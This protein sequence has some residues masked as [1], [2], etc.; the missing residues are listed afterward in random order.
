MTKFLILFFIIFT[1]T[2]LSKDKFPFVK[3]ELLN[4]NEIQLPKDIKGKITVII[5]AFE[6]NA[7][8]QIDPWTEALLPLENN[9]D[10]EYYEI[11]MISGF[12]SFMSGMIDGGM[13]KGIDPKLHDNVATYYGDRDKYFECFNINDKSLCYVFLLDKEGDIVYRDK[14]KPSGDDIKNLK[15]VIEE[16][17]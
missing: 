7:Q 1:I 14:G 13:K 4:G 16:I 2:A 8:K 6:R 11:P 3:A 10:I 5:I 15:A 12:Y 9:N 17:K